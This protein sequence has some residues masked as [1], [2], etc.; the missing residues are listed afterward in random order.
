MSSETRPYK[1][2][3]LHVLLLEDWNVSQQ[4]LLHVSHLSERLAIKLKKFT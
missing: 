3:K 2:E 4:G 1:V